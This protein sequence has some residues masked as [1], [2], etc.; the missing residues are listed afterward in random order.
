MKSLNIEPL[1]FTPFFDLETYMIMSGHKRIQGHEASRIE[2]EWLRLHAMLNGYTLS[3]SKR[4]L[5]L[6]LNP[7]LEQEIDATAENDPEQAERLETIARTLLMVSLMDK[8]PEA[9]FDSC[10]PVPEPNKRLKTTL[11]SL[12]LDFSKT[13]RLNVRYGMITRLPLSNDC[14]SCYISD[15]CAKRILANG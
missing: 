6:Y 4:Y 15:T 10:V 12:G 9:G 14:Q 8:V 2:Q 11:Q 13:G 7:K 5:L 1:R 3:N